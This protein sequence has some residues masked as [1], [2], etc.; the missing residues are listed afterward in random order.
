M[1]SH[2]SIQ[3]RLPFPLHLTSLVLSTNLLASY[4]CN[5]VKFHAA[6]GFNTAS[7][8]E[9]YLKTAF[10]VLYAEGKEGMPKMMTIA[11]H[12]RISGKPGRFA[13]VQNF[14]RYIASKPDVWVTTRRDIA[15][16]YREKF[17]YRKGHLV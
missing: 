15:I 7:G 3:A 12:C 8:F 16:H 6:S 14:V 10:N 17:P 5:N 13:A 1:N 4:D 9:E 11:L 2:D